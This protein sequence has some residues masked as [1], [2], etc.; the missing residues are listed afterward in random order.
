MTIR[1]AYA[2]LVGAYQAYKSLDIHTHD[3][4]SHLIT[5]KEMEDNFLFL[6]INR[7]EAHNH[8]TIPGVLI[9]CTCGEVIENECNEMCYTVDINGTPMRN[10]DG[11]LIIQ[12][13]G[14]GG[15]CYT[16]APPEIKQEIKRIVIN[17]KKKENAQ[18]I[19]I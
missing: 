11:T 7:D 15:M 17:R 14:W 3:W 10:H 12:P 6:D 1:C 2:D 5:I 19:N 13:L 9:T 8:Q 18:K 4:G 16:E